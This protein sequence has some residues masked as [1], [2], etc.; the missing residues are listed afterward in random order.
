MLQNLKWF[1]MATQEYKAGE[2][3]VWGPVAPGSYKEVQVNGKPA[4]LVRG[5]WDYLQRGFVPL[6]ET[7]Q[8]FVSRWDRDA[9]LQLYWPDGDVMYHLYAWQD[10]SAEDLIRMAESAQ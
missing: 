8:E 10:V 4:I 5:D 6:E 1:N 3:T 9:G 2:P 7:R